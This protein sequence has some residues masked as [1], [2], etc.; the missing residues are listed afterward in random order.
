MNAVWLVLVVA[1]V[2]TAAFTGTMEAVSTASVESAKSAVTLALGLIGVMA[3]WL[4][5]MRI[6]QEGGLLHGL[7]RA[8]QPV[9]TRLFPDVP[10]DHP[11]MSAMIMNIATNMLGLG[12][13]A[14]PFGIKAMVE[15]NRLN[16]VPGVATDAMVLFLAINTSNVALAPLGVIALRAA[17]GSHNAAGI[18]LPTLF[19]TSC[20]TVLAIIAAKALQRAVRPA[21]A[22]APSDA[23]IA[24]RS[25]DLPD[26]AE[27]G[28][29]RATAPLG[30]AAALIA[31]VSIVVGLVLQ[32]RAGVAGG[33]ALGEQLRGV[34]STWLLPVLIAAMLGYGMAKR[35]AVY[36]AMIAGAK[37]GF[38]VAVRII[39]F[40]VAI[41]VAA[42]MFRASGLLEILTRL[43]GPF[44]APLGFP[45]EALPMAIL[46]PLSG[47]GAYAVMAEIMQANGPDSYVGYL[48]STLQ[49]STE[50]TFY[51]LAVYFGAVG[52]SRVRHAVA[53]GLIAD[54]SGYIGAVLAVRWLLG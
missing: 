6:V 43:I 33:Q 35:V 34:A 13:A 7:A 45:A 32:L 50:T 1:S 18:W 28:S 27:L 42:G 26:A 53:T 37:E 17:L 12:N 51:V 9:M 52:I 24:A 22:Y 47:S 23:A 25:V 8:L 41:V 4:G 29:E 14:T 49:G 11:A 30:C 31:M 10:P 5:M 21:S 46:R 3:F 20:S 54:L 19:A 15:L 39:P 38:Q 44:T 16:P 40:L 48:V 2:V 36:D